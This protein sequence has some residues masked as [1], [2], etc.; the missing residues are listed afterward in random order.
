[1]ESEFVI[2]REFILNASAPNREHAR[3]IEIANKAENTIS[4]LQSKIGSLE[5]QL[6]EKDAKSKEAPG[7]A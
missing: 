7:K 2:L 3:M 4:S 1:M 6:K 5:K